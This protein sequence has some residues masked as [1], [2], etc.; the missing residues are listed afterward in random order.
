V[1][2]TELYLANGKPAGVY[3]CETCR[4]VY[5]T[6][7]GKDA[8]ENCCVCAE[9]GKSCPRDSGEYTNLHRECFDVSHKR[10]HTER[11]NKAEVCKGYDGWVY[12]EGWGPQ[13]GFFPSPEEAVEYILDQCDDSEEFDPAGLP[14]F[15]FCC[16]P[17][18]PPRPDVEDVLQRFEDN[19]YEGISDDVSGTKELQEALDAFWELNK[20]LISWTMDAKRKVRLV[21]ESN[22]VGVEDP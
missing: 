8:A 18:N 5:G 9:C 10:R 15:A 20:G 19:G 1:N 13:D 2:A 6:A 3:F 11:L 7:H 16:Q 21:Y 12:V 22:A 4:T 17:N 14:Q